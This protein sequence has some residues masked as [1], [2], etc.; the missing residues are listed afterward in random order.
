[1]V[2]NNNGSIIITTT[3]N[4][5]LAEEIGSV[6]KLKPLSPG[7]SKTLLFSR[8][9]FR[10]ILG[11]D[12]YPSDE[13]TEVSDKILKKCGGL[14]L[15][16]ISVGG[17]LCTERSREDIS[18]WR[19][20]YN[21]ID[22]G[23]N[24]DLRM[25]NMRSVLLISY[26]DLPFH[27]RNCLLSISIFPEDCKIRR[28]RLVC[29]WIAEGFVQVIQGCNLLEVGHSYFRELLN[30]GM[31]E[32]VGIN[33]GSDETDKYCRVHDIMLC[34][35]RC[36]SREENFVTVL[37]EETHS[38]P[39]RKIRRLSLQTS[40]VDDA[41]ATMGMYD[42]VRSVTVYGGPAGINQMP[43]LSRFEVL[44]VMDLEGCHLKQSYSLEH[45]GKLLHL[46]YLGLRGT[47]IAE[48]PKN[49]ET[50]RFLQILDIVRTEIKELPPAVAL[51]QRL[52][53]LYVDH[54][55]RL[56][57]RMG[58]LT[59]L[60]ELSNV[61]TTHQS[62]NF[63]RELQKLTELTALGILWH[64]MKE[65]SLEKELLDTLGKL[66]KLQTLNVHGCTE[67]AMELMREEG[68]VPPPD[69]RTFVVRDAWFSLVPSWII[70]SASRLKLTELQIGVRELRQEDL[71]ALG[72]L[73]DLRTLQL[74][75]ERTG[76]GG[77][78][79]LVVDGGGASFPCLR[80]LRLR[81]EACH[82]QLVFQE[83]AGPKVRVVEL[84][85]DVDRAKDSLVWG[86]G[87]LPSL[88][89]LYVAIS[90][91]GDAESRQQEAE[92]ALR[93]AAAAHPNRPTLHM[94]VSS[95]QERHQVNKTNILL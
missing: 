65:P 83:G 29:R 67:S 84:H 93:Q 28:D 3:R 8:I 75:V 23:C 47:L 49:I 20:V 51:L 63:V 79:V 45:V 82:Y 91:C 44:R 73:Q 16:I 80:E 61:C 14:P 85:V 26:Y 12:E 6:Y 56:P 15:A 74:A 68:W 59:S 94:I 43:P 81:G 30:R 19:E 39:H 86:L 60:L 87:S 38:P 37:D 54:K 72:M 35:V 48:L 62:P 52:M 78:R 50:L 66:H 21:S 17:I 40:K 76:S 5:E 57:D 36:L 69:L 4:F 53:C 55:T 32:E 9:N 88:Q 24:F 13:L 89:D 34:L 95:D 2:E 42:Q 46:R 70:R 58:R 18:F 11:G 27:L 41:A 64:E 1:M 22:S 71:Q 25:E 77:G 31:I 92:T 33:D 7:D 90:M 10:R